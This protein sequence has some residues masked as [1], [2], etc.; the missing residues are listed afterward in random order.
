MGDEGGEVPAATALYWML[1]TLREKLIKYLSESRAPIRVADLP[2]F[3]R[4][5]WKITLRRV[6]I[7]SVLTSFLRCSLAEWLDDPELC[8]DA[9]RHRPR[10]PPGGRLWENDYHEVSLA[11]WPADVS[12][13]SLTSYQNQN[14]NGRTE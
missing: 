4:F 6:S 5:Y 12:P 9:R 14:A 11:P 8:R 1:G 10:L 13:A 3:G 7:H 2:I